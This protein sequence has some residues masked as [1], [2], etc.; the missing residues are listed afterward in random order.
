[1]FMPS[2]IR[3]NQKVEMKQKCPSIGGGI[4]KTSFIHTVEYCFKHRKE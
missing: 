4:N 2:T 1:M 3:K